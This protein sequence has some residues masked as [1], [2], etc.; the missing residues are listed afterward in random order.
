M[1][2]PPR[3]LVALALSSGFAMGACRVTRPN[4]E[5]CFHAQGN[6]TCAE[7]DPSRPFCVAPTCDSE[8]YGCV[9]ELPTD[10]SCYSPCGDALSSEDNSSCIEIADDSGSEGDPLPDVADTSDYDCELHAD[11]PP[12]AGFCYFG[13]CTPCDGTSDPDSACHVL[14]DGQ[15][16]VCLDGACVQCSEDDVDECVDASLACDV[17]SHTCVPCTAHDQCPGGAACDLPL[18]TCLPA[19]AVWHVDCDGGQDFTTL[20]AAMAAL[21]E[22]SGT[23]IVHDCEATLGYPEGVVVSGDRSVALFGAEGELPILLLTQVSLDVSNGA[24]VH[25]RRLSLRGAAAIRVSADSY[26][27]L[28]TSVLAP[29][30][31]DALVVDDSDVRVRNSMLTASG[32][33]S[34]AMRVTGGSRLDVVYNTL[35]MMGPH[36]AITCT[37][38]PAFG[39]SVRNNIV[40]NAGPDPAIV[41]TG[42]GYRNN[43]IDNP[44]LYNTG[45][46]ELDEAWFALEDNGDLHLTNVA[47]VAFSSAAIWELGDPTVDFD[48]DPRPARDGTT[49]FA[50]ADRLN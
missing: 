37:N 45:V 27:D 6:E 42:L 1:R 4:P 3:F 19:D 12:E 17:E 44:V 26:L 24:R 34:A 31:D 21:D 2:T 20:A 48:G 28:D 14:T 33:D 29:L 38:A 7:L 40:L 8:P 9:A 50:G 23:L 5:H 35:V 32:F 39:S 49:D 10:P 18:G 22:G 25:A 15:A 16:P 36:P 30:V 47:P 41:C 43:A 46:G 13:V 11:C